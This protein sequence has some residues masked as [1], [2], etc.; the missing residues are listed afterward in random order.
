MQFHL[1]EQCLWVYFSY[2]SMGFLDIGIKK[3]Q[4]QRRQNG[5]GDCVTF[6]RLTAYH[7]FMASYLDATLTTGIARGTDTLWSSS[8]NFFT[9]HLTEFI[10]KMLSGNKKYIYFTKIICTHGCMCVWDTTPLINGTVSVPF[11]KRC[12]S[13]LCVISEYF[14]VFLFQFVFTPFHKKF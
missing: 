10:I 2:L 7:L 5:D 9:R 4:G 3:H 13:V 6:H 1:T 11:K 12:Q 8:E 14:F